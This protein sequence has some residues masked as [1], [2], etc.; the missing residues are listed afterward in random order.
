M[1][2][3][4]LFGGQID[5]RKKV[6]A[7]VMS[8]I[9]KVLV[10]AVIATIA[11]VGAACAGGGGSSDDG[12]VAMLL[13]EN[14]NP[15]WESQDA[16]FFM[17][18]M[19]VI[20][21]GVRVEV[22]NAGNDTATQQRQAEQA[23]TNGALVLVVIPIDGEAAAIIAEIA[24]DAGVPTIAYDRM[25]QSEFTNFWV[26]AD[27]G[28]A[29]ESQAQHV[30]DN[31]SSGDTLL[32]LKGS[33]TDPNADVIYQGQLRVLQ[34]LLDSGERILGHEDWT[35]G[36]DPAIAQRT[37]EQ[38]LTRLDNNIQGVVSSNDGNAGAAVTALEAQGLAGLVPV[39]GLDATVQALQLILLNQQTQ[40]V[41]R[42][43]EK[44]AEATANVTKLLLDGESTAPF[45]QGTVTNE[46]GAEV[47]FVA[48]EFLS[49]V[50]EAGVREVIERDPSI[51]MEDVCTGEAA[52]TS[53][54]R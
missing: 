35:Q 37:T 4:A 42:P 23:L 1:G 3:V 5:R 47:D 27:L 54:C 39:S 26:Q 46:V 16:R 9:R 28:K 25:I 40:S 24:N 11:V 21:P 14:V 36:W 8:K 17:E 44:M 51:S 50:G 41:W 10:V 12:F 53:F 2:F 45:V 30:V 29:G 43:F 52:N 31:T 15:R 34:P 38:A 20:A 33:P 19:S 13:P 22:F 7:K 49:V 48:V 32:L 6:E 18:Q